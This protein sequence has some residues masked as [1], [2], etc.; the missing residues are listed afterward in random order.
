MKTYHLN[1]PFIANVS[2]DVVA[3][4]EDEAI[5]TILDQWSNRISPLQLWE[6]C[7]IDNLGISVLDVSE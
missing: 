6:S 1:V 3:A 5:A 7:D 2:V 4:S